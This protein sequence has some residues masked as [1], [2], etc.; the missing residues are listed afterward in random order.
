MI[1][2]LTPE[3]ICELP[4][5][6]ASG[7]IIKD[8]V[9][10]I[11][12]DDE[13]SLLHGSPEAGFISF[14]LWNEDLPEDAAI[15]KKLKPDFECLVLKGASLFILPSFSRK[16]RITGVRVDLRKEGI[17]SHQILDLTDLRERLDK[18]VPDLNIE[19]AL[20]IN[21]EILL[22]QRGNGKNGTNAVIRGQS[23]DDNSMQVIPI[24]LP[25]MGKI[26]LTITDAAATGNDIWFLA[27][28]EDTESTYLDGEVKGSFLG[29]FDERFRVKELL[30][31]DIPHKPEG[32][33]FHPDG[34]IYFVTDDDS[35]SKPSRLFRIK[36]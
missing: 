30:K 13:V 33:A 9:F 34:S 1:K 7:L 22:F 3:F 12:S 10:Y 4:V 19:G 14:S 2:S 6:A 5:F 8:G 25:H 35:R 32:L 16:N 24:D 15:R 29:S 27:V 26:P 17:S 18:K 23:L 28:A 31:L 36:I 11:I 20:S 21:N